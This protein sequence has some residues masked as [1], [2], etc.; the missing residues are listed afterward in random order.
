MESPKR[1][2]AWVWRWTIGAIA[3]WWASQLIVGVLISLRDVLMIAVVSFLAACALEQPVTRLE[4]RGV[5]RGVATFAVLIVLTV[6]SG[7]VLAAGGAV[8]LSQ[9]QSLRSSLPDLVRGLA[10]L[11]DQIGVQM[12]VEEISSELASRL[13]NAIEVNAGRLLMQSG[14]V[15]GQF[16]AG[17]LL[18]F[19]LV[20]DGP[21]LR[22]TMCSV[23]A[24]RRQA[25][26]LEVWTAAID[27]AGGYF[28]VR[29]ILAAAAAFSSW[30]FFAATQTPYA[31]ALAIWVG[32]IS[33][34][35]PAVGAYLA[36]A[37]PLLVAAGVSTELTIGVAVFLV[38]YQ[39]VENYV[40]S[41]RI[42][43]RVMQVHP[44]VAF[45]AAISGA[46]I[47]GAAGALIAVPI[48]ATIQAVVS[49]SI[50]RHDLVESHLLSDAV[51]QPWKRRKGKRNRR[52]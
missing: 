25:R 30:V 3:C 49:A 41:P 46:V 47:A 24:P 15:I 5:R 50:E 45:F 12:N 31:V 16:A 13:Q 22:R 2:P 23:L 10:P 27:K 51:I 48:V 19:Y 18:V 43:R 4:R 32:V 6:V 8:A 29:G 7:F 36:G 44:A 34:A 37:L 11:L 21:R 20:A 33:Q 52:A 35:I 14:L 28:I 40:L 38:L 1:P 26:M 17:L 42:S 39:Q 9:A